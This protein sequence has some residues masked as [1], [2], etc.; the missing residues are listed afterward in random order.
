MT[1]EQ[2][3]LISVFTMMTEELGRVKDALDQQHKQPSCTLVY[4]DRDCGMINPS[5]I[6]RIYKRYY[7]HIYVEFGKDRGFYIKYNT[8][9]ERDKHYELMTRGILD[10]NER[11]KILNK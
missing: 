6:E 10:C 4:I 11:E 9:A 8:N 5:N 1:L 2:Q 7:R 3:T